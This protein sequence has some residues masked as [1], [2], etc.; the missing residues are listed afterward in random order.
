MKRKAEIRSMIAAVFFVIAVITAGTTVYFALKV[1]EERNNLYKSLVVT[2]NIIESIQTNDSVSNSASTSAEKTTVQADSIKSNNKSA[3]KGLLS[4]L[5]K[6][7]HFTDTTK[8]SAAPS[9]T[10]KIYNQIVQEGN[11]LI[12]KNAE[13]IHL[14]EN[15]NGKPT[16]I[17]IKPIPFDS[18]LIKGL[19]EKKQ[20]KRPILNRIKNKLEQ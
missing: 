11:R 7:I 5:N 8:I 3:Y 16:S 2:K 1:K 17:K 10:T 19:D 15:D 14:I 12:D 18:S 9:D 6:I 13:E 20:R 4:L